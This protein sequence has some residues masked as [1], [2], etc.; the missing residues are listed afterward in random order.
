[1]RRHLVPLLAA[2]AALAAPASAQA[3]DVSDQCAPVS[4]QLETTACQGVD[5]LERDARAVCRR[6]AAEECQPQT[7]RAAIE[8]FEGS[9]VSRALAYQHRL[10]DGVP[11]RNAPWFGT[12]NSFNSIAEMGPALSVMDSNQQLSLVEQLRVGVRSLELDLHWVPSAH[13][14]GAFAPVVC[15]AQGGAGC[16]VEKPLA[17]VLGPVAEWLRANDDQVL[18]L[19]LENQL[20]GE[21]GSNAAAAAIE[22]QLGDLVYRPQGPAG[23]CVEVPLD[24]TR[25]DVLAA[26]R[27]V[28]IVSNCG[29]GAAWRGLSFGWA[30]HEETRPRGFGDGCEAD[31]DR[32]TF[33]ATLIRYYEDDTWLTAGAS[34]VGAA[35]RDDGIDATTAAAM[36]RCGVDLLGFDQ[37]TAA[38]ARHEAVVWSWAEGE[39]PAAACAVMRSDGRWEGRPC[40]ERRRF[41]CRSAHG[42][43]TV[44]GE[45]LRGNKAPR[46]CGLPR[47]GWENEQVAAAAA[48]RE[49]WLAVRRPRR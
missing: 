41:A 34:N 38:D 9:W 25:H 39:S 49:V 31:F 8:A 15:H 17:T 45:A 7:S 29:A 36:A 3:Q 37:L 30:E 14:G 11:L 16:T 20:G 1:M 43:V 10:G 19:Y 42:S 21:T 28:L 22:A 2:V 26:G 47:T 33:D 18:L 6:Y 32:A 40:G 48:G 12:H 46:G 23:Q 4:A 13:A 27:Q 35:S 5:V 44:T 24:A